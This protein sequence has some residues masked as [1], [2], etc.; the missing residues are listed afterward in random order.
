MVKCHKSWKLGWWHCSP[1]WLADRCH[2]GSLGSPC[3]PCQASKAPPPTWAAWIVFASMNKVIFITLVYI[4]FAPGGW[5]CWLL[6]EWAI[7]VECTG[8]ATWYLTWWELSPTA[9]RKWWASLC[10]V[11][12][13]LSR[14]LAGKEQGGQGGGGGGGPGHQMLLL[15]K[16]EW[17]CSLAGEAPHPWQNS[18]TSPFSFSLDLDLYL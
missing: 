11:N 4:S 3:S 14:C 13:V 7:S 16:L 2:R 15:A 8:V 5:T 1:V 10:R 12:F 6:L 18:F 9:S 17:S